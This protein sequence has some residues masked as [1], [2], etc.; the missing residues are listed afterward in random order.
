MKHRPKDTPFLTK[1]GGVYLLMGEGLMRIR[2]DRRGLS[3][4]D[5]NAKRF[6]DRSKSKLTRT[7]Q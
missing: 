6:S 7:F 4:Q 5:T 2:L 1:R 3:G